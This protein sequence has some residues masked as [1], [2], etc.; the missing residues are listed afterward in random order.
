MC[1]SAAIGPPNAALEPGDDLQAATASILLSKPDCW[2]TFDL[3]PQAVA[4]L[5][6]VNPRPAGRVFPW[7]GR[8]A[9]YAAVDAV[10]PKGV[11]WRPHESRRAVVTAIVRATGSP[12]A[13]QYVSHANLK[14]TLRYDRPEQVGPAIRS[15][16]R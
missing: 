16:R 1:P 12:V 4:T 8:S 6:A 15:W 14:T 3:S 5:A 13:V 9:V 7:H 10:A 11:R 2:V